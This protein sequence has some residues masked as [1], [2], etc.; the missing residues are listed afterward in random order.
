MADRKAKKNFGHTAVADQAPVFNGPVLTEARVS[1]V[2]PE[3]ALYAVLSSEVE[4]LLNDASELRRFFTHFFAVIDDAERD[5]YIAHF[6]KHPPTVTL[7]YPRSGLDFPIITIVLTGE[8]EEQ[9]AIGQY[10]GETLEDEDTPLGGSSEYVGALMRSTWSVFI[11]AQNPDACL[12]LYN[13]VKSVVIGATKFLEQAGL[14]DITLS[15]EDLGPAGEEY[16]PE[17]MF[18]RVLRV[19][20]AHQVTVPVLQTPDPRRAKLGGIF[21]SDVVVDGRPGAVF[22]YPYHEENDGDQET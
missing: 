12:Y 18:M 22:T 2:M 4:R 15:G 10:M 7:G 9:P 1:V 21:G 17:N 8:D 14:A 19:T 16:L 3:R 20:A 6:Q 13:L 11:Y 5:D